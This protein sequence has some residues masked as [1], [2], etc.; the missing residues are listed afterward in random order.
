MVCEFWDGTDQSW[1]ELFFSSFSFGRFSFLCLTWKRARWS[2]SH[3]SPVRNWKPTLQNS[4]EQGDRLL[5]SIYMS[6]KD[7]IMDALNISTLSVW[8][9]F[10]WLLPPAIYPPSSNSSFLF[11]F[12]PVAGASKIGTTW[13]FWYSECIA[14]AKFRYSIGR[15]LLIVQ[16]YAKLDKVGTKFTFWN[17]LRINC[18]HG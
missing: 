2:P 4:W 18:A 10:L 14:R 13:T 6:S 17:R 1:L 12:C 7:F 8:F 11:P 16:F 15:N 5:I 9:F 3:L